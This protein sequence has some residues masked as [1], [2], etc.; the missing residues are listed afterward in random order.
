M[1]WLDLP[2]FFTIAIFL[3]MLIAAIQPVTDPDFWWH[4]TTGNWI[5]SQHAIPRTD[6]YTYTVAGHRWITHEWLSEVILAALYA[7]R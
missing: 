2:H 3:T 7:S 5:L 1:R 4:L 6:L